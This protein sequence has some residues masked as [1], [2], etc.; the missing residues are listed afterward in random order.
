MAETLCVLHEDKKAKS[1]WDLR[2][3]G[4]GCSECLKCQLRQTEVFEEIFDRS[5]LVEVMEH[6]IHLEDEF[7]HR[8]EELS[9]LLGGVNLWHQGN[10]FVAQHTAEWSRLLG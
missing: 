8:D 1:G 10:L 4:F 7:V 2:I 9:V 3:E 5:G 6:L